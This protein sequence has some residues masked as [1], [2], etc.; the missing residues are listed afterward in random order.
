[1]ASVSKEELKS[2]VSIVEII[3]DY[4][5]LKKAGASYKGL[6]PFHDDKNPSL[7][8]SEDKAMFHCFSCKAGGDVFTFLQKIN[9]SSFIEALREVAERA[10][11]ELERGGG[12]D[13]ATDALFD[14]NKAV[15]G[16][17]RKSLESQARESR[18]ALEYLTGRGVTP[19]AAEK[20]QLGYAPA[21]AASIPDFIKEGGFSAPR[22]LEAGLLSRGERGTTYGKFRSRLIFPILSPDS[23]VLGF[24]GRTLERDGV[25]KYLNSSESAVYRKRRSLYGLH[26]TRQDIKKSGVCVLV[27]GYFDLLSVYGAG[28]KNVAASLGTSLTRDQVGIIKR[29][30]EDVV[31]LYDGDRAGVD[32]SFTAGEVFLSGGVVP[33][34]ARPPEGVDPDQFARENGAEALRALI[35][36]APPL[37]EVL[38][39]DVSSALAEN[40]MSQ[41][42]AA[43]RLMSVVPV[44]GNS[45]EIGP[46][47]REVSRRFGFREQD[48]Y[49]TVRS[50]GA[51]ARRAVKTA[52]SAG[53]EPAQQVS[54]AE[55]MLLRISLK[56]PEMAE[57]L[58]EEQ[59][60]KHI[61]DGE[62][63]KIIS[64]LRTS[65]AVFP[66]DSEPAMSALLSR[67]HFTLDEIEF[68]NGENVGVE[69][70]KCL[71]R[72]K[73]VA[74]DKEMKD[75]RE[76][77]RQI[78]SGSSDNSAEMEDLM[79]RYMD[80]I[81]LRKTIRGGCHDK[82]GGDKVG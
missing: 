32:S 5:S 30:A 11:V 48:L 23:K 53:E 4:V 75:L 28:V 68:M 19:E 51:P 10:G 64:S 24:G 34:I 7:H 17:F 16:F 20:F 43:K 42:A 57:F 9:G 36:S 69:I 62:V 76:R 52:Q 56:F 15:C 73:M 78:E 74:I 35:D 44:M 40:R 27:E 37:T 13:S 79:K 50:A 80:L 49:S 60:M 63:K 72:L 14:M 33:R 77:L 38:M 70:E 47:V 71:V 29:Y 55:M 45:P 1:M 59:V 46:Y 22:A 31:I 12:K 18:K 39:R 81:E 54:A 25:P 67:A 21:A 2:R 61:P 8:V 66:G 82:G 65:G 26:M 3:G 6:C 41:S 58:C